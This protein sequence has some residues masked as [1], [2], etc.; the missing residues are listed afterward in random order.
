MLSHLLLLLL[1]LLLLVLLL[2][3]LRLARIFLCAKFKKTS[4]SP[5]V[6]KAHAVV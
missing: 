6:R 1:L 3:T 2:L 4:A 5:I